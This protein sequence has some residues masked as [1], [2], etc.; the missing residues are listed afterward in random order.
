MVASC[1]VQINFLDQCE[2]RIFGSNQF[3][4]TLN[5]RFDTLLTFCPG[6]FSAIHKEA[7]VR[8]VGSETNIVGQSGIFFLGCQCVS[9]GCS[10]GSFLDLQSLIIRNAVI[11]CKEIDQIC[12]QRNQNDKQE[13]SENF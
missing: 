2:I 11:A 3:S 1:R 4:G 7:E 13:D 12:N 10:I 9:C 5:I 8:R 6:R